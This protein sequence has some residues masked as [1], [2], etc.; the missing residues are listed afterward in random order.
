MPATRAR[1]AMAKSMFGSGRDLRLTS[2]RTAS[3]TAS[4]PDFG[5]ARR[6][7]SS[8]RTAR[9]SPVR[10]TKCPNPGTFSPRRSSSPTTRGTSSG[11]AAAASIAS[12]PSDAP[13]CSAPPTAPIPV[14]TTA[15]GSARTDA[16][17][18]AASVD[19]ASSWSASRTSAADR[20]RRSAG[21]ARR[22]HS[23]GHN[24]SAIG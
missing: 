16:A 6:T 9:G 11:P 20:A 23:R 4:C 13:P 22:S 19:A 1:V 14:A 3:A 5:A 24:R 18:R 21:L 12:A 8:S 2:A 7:R 17:A 10:Y 15:Y